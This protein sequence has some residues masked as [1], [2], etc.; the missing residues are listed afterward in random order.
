MGAGAGNTLV[1]APVTSKDTVLAE[2]VEAQQPHSSLLLRLCALI[3]WLVSIAFIIALGVV[4]ARKAKTTTT[5][6]PSSPAPARA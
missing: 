6:S 5:S 1:S 4:A 2:K 3:G